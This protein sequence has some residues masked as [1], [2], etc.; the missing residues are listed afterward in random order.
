MKNKPTLYNFI[1]ILSVGG[2][3]PIR[4]STTRDYDIILTRSQDVRV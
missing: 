1:L 3:E 2:H 4:F